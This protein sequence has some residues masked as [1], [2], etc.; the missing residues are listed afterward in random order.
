MALKDITVSAT[1]LQAIRAIHFYLEDP[2]LSPELPN[3]ENKDFDDICQCVK[4]V[5]EWLDE[6]HRDE[7]ALEQKVCDFI[8]KEPVPKSRYEMTRLILHLIFVVLRR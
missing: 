4:T 3:G 5:G 2:R 1:V 7:R 6:V 8:G